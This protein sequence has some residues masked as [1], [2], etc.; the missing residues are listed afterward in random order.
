MS[1]TADSDAYEVGKWRFCPA[2]GG[3]IEEHFAGIGPRVEDDGA[4]NDDDLHARPDA[5]EDVVCAECGRPW[6][7]CPCWLGR[8]KPFPPKDVQISAF[9]ALR[10]LIASEF[11]PGHTLTQLAGT[12]S[13]AQLDSADVAALAAVEE[14]LNRRDGQTWT[15]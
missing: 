10:K 3:P 1:E 11:P 6:I 14:F 5:W 12:W 8:G 7:A 9:R 2:C 15:S 13:I 4:V